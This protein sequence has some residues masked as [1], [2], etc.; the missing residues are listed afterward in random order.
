[1]S[2]FAVRG[3]PR[4]VDQVT[5]VGGV[6][7]RVAVGAGAFV[8]MGLQVGVWS[9]L[10]AD[11]AGAL[12][13]SPGT[14]GAALIVQIVAMIVSVVVGG[15]VVD[16]IGRRP[17]AIL[18][19]ALG[20][21][22]FLLFARV[23]TVTGLVAVLLIFGAG[24]SLIDISANAI[25]ADIERQ[26]HTQVMNW[27][28]AGY[29]IGL[30]LGAGLAVLGIMSGW[31]YRSVFVALALILGVFAVA[32]VRLPMPRRIHR[33]EAPTALA[34]QIDGGDRRH[35]WQVI[36]APAVLLLTCVV[37]A[38]YLIESTFNSFLSLYLRSVFSSGAALAGAGVLAVA[39]AGIAG[40]LIGGSAVRQ[41]GSRHTFL[42]AAALV[43]VGLAAAVATGSALVTLIGLLLVAFALA[44]VVPT[45]LSEVAR[46]MPSHAGRAVGTVGAVGYVAI[47][48]GPALTGALADQT[49]L[50][51]AIG[52]LMLAAAAIAVAGSITIPPRAVVGT[53]DRELSTS[54]T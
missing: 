20:G 26:Y 32:L 34:S 23:D 17:V 33:G 36:A 50:R 11:L 8:G 2:F 18:G 38:A 47:A 5:A 27:L 28:H 15:Q 48:A 24:G 14:L 19:F 21:V 52:A 41:V 44:P 22:A 9:V 29:S 46:A 3:S 40:R 45:A 7:V 6:R 43:L 30:A 10:I 4:A 1:V 35:A 31:Q 53:T 13:L 49:S 12:R 16:R 37:F 54:D 42:L 25:G 51:F 39:I